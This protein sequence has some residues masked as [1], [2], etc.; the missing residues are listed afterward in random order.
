MAYTRRDSTRLEHSSLSWKSN[1]PSATE[2]LPSKHFRQ[3]SPM[4]LHPTHPIQKERLRTAAVTDPVLGHVRMHTNSLS[5]SEPW[6][7]SLPTAFLLKASEQP[8]DALPHTEKEWCKVRKSAIHTWLQSAHSPK[9]NV[10]RPGG[11]T[12]KSSCWKQSVGQ[13]QLW[14]LLCSDKVVIYAFQDLPAWLLKY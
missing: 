3:P 13:E 8:R 11:V 12:A 7:E 4:K 9:V 6:E 5:P 10:D 2:I 1:S 14:N